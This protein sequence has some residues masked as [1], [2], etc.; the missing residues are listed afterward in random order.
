MQASQAHIQHLQDLMEMMEASLSHYQSLC[1][2][3]TRL[4]ACTTVEEVMRL[5]GAD[6]PT[7]LECDQSRLFLIKDKSGK[8]VSRYS[9]TL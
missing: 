7:L 1:P 3:L 2:L 5:V 9:H 6:V 8:E 4:G